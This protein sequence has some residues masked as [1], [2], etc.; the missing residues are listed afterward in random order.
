MAYRR[1]RRSYARRRRYRR[2]RRRFFRKVSALKYVAQPVPHAAV[3]EAQN[4]STT[5]TSKDG[6]CDVAWLDLTS[7]LYKLARFTQK[8]DGLWYGYYTDED[9]KTQMSE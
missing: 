3:N 6:T 5:L 8:S 1:Y 4:V 2:N 7:Q 9:G